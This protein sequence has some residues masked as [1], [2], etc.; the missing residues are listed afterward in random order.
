[1]QPNPDTLIQSLALWH[2]DNHH[3]HHCVISI[4]IIITVE[5]F[6]VPGAPS[7]GEKYWVK[8]PRVKIQGENFQGEDSG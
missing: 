8:S 6:I 1:L 4:N 2:F 3:H 5:P 7:E